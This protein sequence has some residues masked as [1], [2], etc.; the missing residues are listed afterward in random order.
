MRGDGIRQERTGEVFQRNA[1]TPMEMR[2]T[3]V[4]PANNHITNCSSPTHMVPHL[5]PACRR[6]FHGIGL[7]EVTATEARS[8]ALLFKELV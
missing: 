8:C 5:P 3:F 4:W 6:P 1:K 2:R 7:L